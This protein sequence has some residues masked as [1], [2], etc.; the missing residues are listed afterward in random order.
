MDELRIDFTPGIPNRAVV[1]GYVIWSSMSCGDRPIHSV[2]TICWFSPI[3]GMAS[4]GTGSEGRKVVFQPKGA[5]TI[6]QATKRIIIKMVTNLFSRKYLMSLWS[7]LKDG[8][9]E[10]SLF[11]DS[12]SQSLYNKS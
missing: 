8:F 2:K 11:L 10:Q 7:I 6:P 1:K 9:D 12:K 4:T 3:S 5:V